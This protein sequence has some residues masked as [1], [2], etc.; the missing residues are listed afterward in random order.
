MPA[1]TAPVNEIGYAHAVTT[2]NWWNYDDETTPELR[3]PQSVAVYDQMRRTDAQ[4]ASVLRAVTL[5][6]R[7]TPWR[8]DPAGARAR[9]VQLVA[10]D[11]V[12]ELCLT[13]APSLV[14]GAASRIVNGPAGGRLVPLALERVLTADGYLFLRYVRR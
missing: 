7:R 8:V 12:D 1:A 5:P 9:V 6:V 4:V 14:G 13:L 3:W 2:G 10:D 11:L